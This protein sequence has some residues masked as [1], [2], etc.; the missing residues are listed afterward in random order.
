MM[1]VSLGYRYLTTPM[2]SLYYDMQCV[3]LKHY[4]IIR[5]GCADIGLFTKIT[6]IIITIIHFVVVTVGY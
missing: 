5:T 1:L 6:D 4:C 3:M 2:W